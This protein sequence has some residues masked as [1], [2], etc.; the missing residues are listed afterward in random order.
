[1]WVYRSL[2]QYSVAK[3]GTGLQLLV[4][5][6]LILL[7]LMTP[8]LLLAVDDATPVS[9]IEA[10][11]GALQEE[12]PLTG[13][14][15]TIRRA[16]I[17]PK[18]DGYI[19]AMNVDQG[20]RVKQGDPLLLL[21]QQLAD[22]AISRVKAQ[23]SEARARLN[24][25]KRQRDEA[26]ELVEK[27]H[28]ASTAF[29]SA[30]AEV[31]IN[32]AVVQRLETELQQQRVIAQRHTV[33]A[34]F[35]GV[36]TEKLV[37]VGQWVEGNTPLFVLTE[38]DPL[39]VEVPVPQF[40]FNRI[41][42]DTPVLI[43]FDALP[44]QEFDARVTTRVPVSNQ[45]ARTFPVLIDISNERQIITPGMSARVT[46]QLTND[47]NNASLLLPRDA[48]VLKPD[49]TKTVWVVA[50]QS[51]VAKANPVEVKTGKSMRETIEITAG[52]VSI[53]DRIVVKGN[54]LLQPGQAVNII[55]QLDY[56]L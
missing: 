40:Y 30:A 29:E 5:M 39:R 55:E 45:T 1:M 36:I 21:D 51:G 44:K 56:K 13:S 46:F 22:L 47:D 17:S 14:V 33:Y 48:I 3:T 52:A 26:A 32:K 27:K 54:E 37:E 53:G 38:L 12:V 20:D 19:E 7:L 8:A 4:G 9:I 43:R 28:I 35:D 42:V 23:L 25:F 50:D 11:S 34:P 49:G 18:E 15:T 2:T 24:E 16:R 41:N 31:E 6:S 10:K